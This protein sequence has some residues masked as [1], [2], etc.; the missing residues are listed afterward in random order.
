MAPGHKIGVNVQC[1][2]KGNEFLLKHEYQLGSCHSNLGEKWGPKVKGS[3]V[4][5]EK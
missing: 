1:G 4:D 2:W 5:V 3:E